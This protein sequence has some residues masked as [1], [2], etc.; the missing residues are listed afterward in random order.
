MQNHNSLDNM[1]LTLD[2]VSAVKKIAGTVYG[3]PDCVCPTIANTAKEVLSGSVF[4]LTGI[5]QKVMD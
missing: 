5:T 2:F 3:N 4:Q 1:N